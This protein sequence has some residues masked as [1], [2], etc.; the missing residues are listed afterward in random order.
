M[1]RRHFALALLAIASLAACRSPARRPKKDEP[2]QG[3]TTY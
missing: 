1:N 3:T 2:N